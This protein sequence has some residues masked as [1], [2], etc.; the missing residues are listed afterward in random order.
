M[1]TSRRALTAF[2]VLLCGCIGLI[3]F[4]RAQAQQ[5]QP[6]FDPPLIGTFYLLSGQESGLGSPPY[7]FDPYGGSLPVYQVEGFSNSY[8]VADSLEDYLA[9]RAQKEM[10]AALNQ[11]SLLDDD[12]PPAPGE[13]SGEG[14]DPPDV[15]PAYNYGTNDLWLEIISMTNE[16]GAF[17]I[18]S[19]ETNA[20]YDLFMT[21]NLA[22]NVPGLNLT[23]WA[24]LYRTAPGETN[25][26]IANLRAAQ[27][28]FRLGTMTD[29]DSDSL[30]D[31]YEILV[32]HTD[33]ND[34][35]TDGDGI[36]D[37]WEV[38]HGLN[39]LVDDAGNDPD[40]DG[41]TNSQEYQNGTNPFDNMLIAWGDDFSGQSTA[42]WGFGAVSAMA[43]GATF[44]NGGHTLVLLPD[45]T[46]TVWGDNSSGQTNV[47]ANLSN[48]V[49]I[50]AGGGQNAALKSDGSVL[51]WGR[52]F[53]DVPSGL[54]NAIRISAGYQ[55]LLA[56]RADGTVVSWGRSNCPANIVLSGLS[57]VQAISAGWNHNVAL[58][59]N[60]TVVTWGLDGESL[61]WNLTNTPAN[62]TNAIAI[63]A[64]ALHSVA[65]LSDGAVIAW[66]NNA[67][68]ETNVPAE[69]TN[70]VAISAGRGYTLAL[71]QDGTVTAWGLGSP[72]VLNGLD[73]IIDI[74]AG[75][76]HAMAIRQGVLTPLIVRQ[77]RSQ[78]TAAGGVARFEVVVSSR[79]EPACQ[80]QFNGTNIAGATNASLVISNVQ[81]SAQG[82]YRVRV[83]NGAGTVFSDEAEFVLVLPPQIIS[84]VTPEM[85]WAPGRSNHVL[86]VSA[87]AQ[88]SQYSPLTYHWFKDG[89]PAAGSL[90]MS[91]LTLGIVTPMAPGDYWAVVT[92]VAGT[93]TSAVWTVRVVHE[94]SVAAWGANNFGQADFPESA[95]NVIALAAG[96][97]HAAA[98]REDGSV[99][100][101][102]FDWGGAPGNLTN[103]VTV[104]AGA[105]HTLALRSDGTVRAWGDN[106][107]GQTN[108]PVNLT[109][110][111]AISA[112][113]NQSLA[114]RS[115][116]TVVQWG[117]T[118]GSIPG[119]LTNATAIASGTAFHIALRANGTVSAWGTN[120]S[121]QTSVPAS[122]SNAVAIA[123]GHA[124]AL[125][126]KVDGTVTA[127]GANGSGQSSVP[128][129]LSNVMA[130]AAGAAHC[131]AL[132][133]DGTVVAWGSNNAGQ[134]NVPTTLQSVK[135]IAAGGN[136]ALAS[137]FSPLVQYTVEASK[138]LLLIY[139]TNSADSV[140]V[141]DY[142]LAHRPMAGNA[143][144]LGIDCPTNEVIDDITFTN[145]MLAP[146]LDW[147]SQNPTRRPQY[148]VL[149]LD[150]PSRVHNTNGQN[151]SSASMR[152]YSSPSAF[153][154]F[155][156]HINMNGTN[157]CI[158]YINKLAYIG[159]NYS[160]GK[161]LIS[162]SAGGY[163]NT[164]YVLDGIRKGGEE[165][166]PYFEDF[167][168][169]SNVVSSARA[170][171][172]AAGLP[173]NHIWFYDGIEVLSNGFF[174]ALPHPTGHP[175]LAG[176]FCWGYH[177][178]LMATYAT[179]GV[180]QWSG[181]SG[182][183]IIETI[184]SFNGWRQ[185]DHGN[186]IR[187]FAPN[188]FGGA[189]YTNTPVG[190]VTHVW[191]PGLGGIN[192]PFSYFGLWA[193]RKGFAIAAW[194]SRNT[195]FFQAVGDPLV[196]R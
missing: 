32:L 115:D 113:G 183:W 31:A 85:V 83:T 5:L 80:W 175:N 46:L 177:S 84:P 50:A 22:S 90:S 49:S 148:M 100:S 162:A 160:P 28:F 152:L 19:P 146:Y 174:Y 64:G 149:F 161:L 86:S 16:V 181:N 179:N 59:G 39:P 155:V 173:T 4:W 63:S 137:V 76:G 154:P 102:G 172:I 194:N 126:L 132:K 196:T 187:W 62:L 156:T 41:F 77:P 89:A 169:E 110:A 128:A 114:L 71:R 112:G 139:N 12:P 95:T 133:N 97:S 66:G 43:G 13:G 158:G 52:T 15:P 111:T 68:G 23:N 167:A 176:Y 14:G 130:V 48:I 65:L 142:Y 70:V 120:G 44:G 78:G 119:D 147:L 55:H 191:E 109:N 94:G 151:F 9:L 101:W 81:S 168:R 96:E 108:V 1:K 124:H 193:S 164:N 20:V 11:M 51:Q 92:N 69:L 135:V 118:H 185:S 61:G 159:T 129:G 107:A 21:T 2:A 186:F 75:P 163:G 87:T 182:W 180:V 123:A 184:E 122:L 26:T 104:A 166:Q 190:A 116:G 8:L 60:G 170:G 93:A 82:L 35:D 54:T 171:L 188:A 117:Q 3:L 144:V 143:N 103:A 30:T 141:K 145:Q 73:Q 33:P 7:P 25:L 24:W 79:R 189:F 138:D 121:G 136:H 18:H 67:G 99:V 56:L 27:G 140:F 74:A 105:A 37:G 38:A 29:S 6:V 178:S 53:E 36:P 165:W 127:W 125:A 134:T 91:N 131:I 192:N 58:R 40:D 157:D 10:L 88:G 57:N 106:S 72:G 45:T 153:R 42:P 195:P 47:P 17:V 98:V 150:V 34:A